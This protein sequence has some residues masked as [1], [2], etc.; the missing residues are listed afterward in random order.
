VQVLSGRRWIACLRDACGLQ[1]PINAC[2]ASNR[3]SSSTPVEFLSN[4][5]L[6]GAN[7]PFRVEKFFNALER[8]T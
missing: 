7:S 8:H 3:K 6:L 2:V 5:F 4:S 1:T